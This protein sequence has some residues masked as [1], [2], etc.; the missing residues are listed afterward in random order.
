MQ[1]T[2]SEL[3]QKQTAPP[4]PLD[5]DVP[6]GIAAPRFRLGVSTE[7]LVA[8]GACILLIALFGAMVRDKK[9]NFRFD[10]APSPTPPAAASQAAAQGQQAASAPASPGNVQ[11]LFD[12]GRLESPLIAPVELAPEA[13]MPM[14][15]NTDFAQQPVYREIREADLNRIYATVPKKNKRALAKVASLGGY[16]SPDEMARAFGYVS[17][18]QMLAA[19][20]QNLLTTPQF[21]PENFGTNSMPFVPVGQ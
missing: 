11:A 6:H 1:G 20:D 2:L 10:A 16:Q 8:I 7:L 13:S 5:S 21:L 18:D 3:L 17:V 14:I 12:Q 9:V 15:P 4:E 19:W